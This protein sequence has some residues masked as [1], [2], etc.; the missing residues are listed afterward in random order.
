MRYIL[1]ITLFV[2]HITG[3]SQGTVRGIVTDT[4]GA[5][6]P[7]ATVTLPDYQISAIS[8]KQG[9]YRISQIPAG[10]LLMEVNKDGF[11]SKILSIK[12]SAGELLDINL[13]LYP[14]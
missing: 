3:F 8:D 10:T 5:V 1:F 2:I 12:I 9:S 13:K 4:S 6:V 7:G 14:Y 11:K